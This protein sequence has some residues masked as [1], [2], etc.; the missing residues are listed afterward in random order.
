M[1]FT[2]TELKGSFLIE[3]E[4][5]EDPRRFITSTD[6]SRLAFNLLTEAAGLLGEHGLLEESGNSEDAREAASTTSH[7]PP[8]RTLSTQS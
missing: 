8:V 7:T 5:R 2:E 1:I 6:G 4:R 3:P